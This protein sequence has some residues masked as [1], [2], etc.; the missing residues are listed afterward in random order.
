MKVTCFYGSM[1]TCHIDPVSDGVLVGSLHWTGGCSCHRQTHS[2][3]WI[4]RHPPPPRPEPALQLLYLQTGGAQ[5]L[6]FK[7]S[8]LHSARETTMSQELGLVHTHTHTHTH[9]VCWWVGWRG[10]GGGY[11]QPF[12]FEPPTS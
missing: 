1:L 6:G 3:W 8:T 2:S 5:A 11:Q 9:T 10:G 4:A 7:L 12:C